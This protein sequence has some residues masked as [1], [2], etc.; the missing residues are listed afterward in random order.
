MKAQCIG[1]LLAALTGAIAAKAE[2]TA[3]PLERL[4]MDREQRAALERLRR[5]PPA[6][7]PKPKPLGQ[8]KAAADPPPPAE[9]LRLNGVVSRSSGKTTTWINGRQR[10]DG[11]APAGTRLLDDPTA[12]GRLSVV[13]NRGEKPIPV[14]VGQTVDRNRR[15]VNDPI[16]STA[17]RVPNKPNT[18]RSANE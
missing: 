7:L 1:V 16:P 12:P 14:K 11:E 3:D 5:L 9:P 10:H 2:E 17:I 18:A 6:E 13:I 8:P 15:K 4:F